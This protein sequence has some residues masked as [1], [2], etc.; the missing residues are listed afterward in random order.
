[1]PPVLHK[2][3]PKM[4]ATSFMYSKFSYQRTTR[5][6]VLQTNAGVDQLQLSTSSAC[7]SN[8]KKFDKAR[9]DFPKEGDGN[10]PTKHKGL[11]PIAVLF[12]THV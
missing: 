5:E 9:L 1:M 11:I 8:E 3:R 7:A 4:S 6:L 10:K 2:L 12:K